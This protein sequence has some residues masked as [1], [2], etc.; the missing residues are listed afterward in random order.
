MKEAL[1]IIDALEENQH[2]PATW[3]TIVGNI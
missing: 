1:K 3:H 2:V